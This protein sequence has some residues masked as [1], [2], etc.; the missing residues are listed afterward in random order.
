MFLEFL[1]EDLGVWRMAEKAWK[2]APKSL[3]LWKSVFVGFI[4]Q[5]LFCK[6]A[7]NALK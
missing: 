1:S 3:V 2:T 7:L 4:V 5:L 6:L